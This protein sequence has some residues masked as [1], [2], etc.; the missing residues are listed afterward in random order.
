MAM[1][2]KGGSDDS[3]LDSDNTWRTHREDALQV[4]TGGDVVGIEGLA[5][6]DG[7]QGPRVVPKR[8]AVVLFP[9]YG[10]GRV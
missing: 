1:E 3:N 9:G 6:S 7:P 10:I 4:E 5:R 2:I 8:G